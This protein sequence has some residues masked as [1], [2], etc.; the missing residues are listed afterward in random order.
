MWAPPSGWLNS[1][2]S[3]LRHDPDRA[4]F[5]LCQRRARLA[6]Q[7]GPGG[8][9]IIP[10]APERQRNR[11]SDFLYR[12]D[13]YFYY[14][15][16]FTEPGAWL[17]LTSRWPQHAVLPAQGP[18]ARDLGRLPP[19]PRG[20]PRR[21]GR[22][23]VP[24]GGRAGHA[25]PATPAGKPQ[26]ASGTP[27]P[28]TAA[29]R[30]GGRLAQPP[31]APACA[32][33]RCARQ[34]ARPVRAARRDAPHQR[35]ARAGRDAPR[36]AISA[37][38][39]HPRH[40]ASARML[41]AGRGRARIPP[42]RRTAARFPPPR[43]AVPGLRQHRRRRGQRLRA[44]LPRRCRAR[45]RWRTGADRRGLRAGRLRQRH[46]PHLPGQ[47]ALSPARSARC[48]TWC[49]PARKPPWPPPAP[50]PAS[51]TRTRPPWPC[52]PR[53]CSTWACS[54][55]NKVG[56]AQDVIASRAYFQFYMHRT[57]H[58]LGMDVHDCG[59]YVE[60]GE[61]GQHQRTQRP[62][63]GRNHHQPPQPHPAPRHGA[64]HRARPVRAPGARRARAFWNIGIRIEDDAIV[65]ADGLRADH[66]RRAGEGDEIE[67]LMR[68]PPGRH[69][70]AVPGGKTA[71]SCGISHRN[72]SRGGGSAIP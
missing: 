68:A 20:R 47:R 56:T 26:P 45:A 49:W 36:R 15:T 66:A 43:L 34:Q 27:L 57:G 58:W 63:V 17:V 11:D 25:T 24:F 9:A 54:T 35:R 37:R 55:S 19:R 70:T 52:W 8:I 3:P 23:C 40:A 38:R 50:A 60:P 29:W 31:C 22:G 41:R 21:T 65:T 5:R 6:A 64:D 53:A 1:T 69:G 2:Q 59:S 12:H 13:S 51:P 44:A 39:P 14:L 72:G 61:V 18:G 28:R 71:R 30:A 42:G 16:G 62:A 67:A 4:E 32:L 46:H 48:T 10:T 7:L 33:A